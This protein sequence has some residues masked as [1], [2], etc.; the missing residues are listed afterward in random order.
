MRQAI[1]TKYIGAT[2][3]KPS[4]VKAI[5]EAGSVTLSWDHASN[6]EG[7]HDFA[8]KA[9]AEKFGWTG[10]WF[11]GGLPDHSG[12]CYVWSTESDPHAFEIAESIA[13]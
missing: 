1:V 11:C 7:N 9:L 4:R 13:A 2:N 8:A 6:I 3:S 12:N 10:K 5:A